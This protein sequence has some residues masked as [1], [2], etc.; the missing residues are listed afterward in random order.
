MKYKYIIQEHRADPVVVGA[1]AWNLWQIKDQV[2]VPEFVVVS[3]GAFQYFKEHGSIPE[4]L[5][6]EVVSVFNEIFSNK[7]IAV[8]SSGTAEDTKDRSYAGMYATTLNVSGV[9]ATIKAI[10]TVWESNDTRRVQSYR[11]AHKLVPG[12]MAVILQQQIDADVSGVMTTSGKQHGGEVIIECC[13]GLGDKLVSGQ[14]TP[15]RYLMKAKKILEHTGKDLLS[16]RQRFELYKTGQ[17]LQRVLGAP[18][19]IEW[20]YQ[21]NRLYILQAR[22]LTAAVQTTRK[23]VTVWCNANLRETIPDPIS[24]M[25]YSF[26]NEIWLPDIIINVFGFPLTRDQ[27]HEYPPVERVLGRMYWNLNNTAAYGRSIAPILNFMKGGAAVDPQFG[28]AMESIDI[29]YI[30]QLVPAFTMIRFTINAM[31]RMPFFLF[32]TYWRFRAAAQSIERAFL[33]VDQHAKRMAPAHDL[34]SGINNVREWVQAISDP[35][36]KRYFSGLLISV[37]YLALLIKLLGWR[38][39]KKGEAIARM[40]TYGLIDKTGEMVRA[41]QDLSSKAQQKLDSLSGKALAVLYEQDPAFHKQFDA[42]LDEFGHRGPAEFD[43]AS[44]NWR[45]DPGQ[46]L[47]IIKNMP[48][49][50]HT[51]SRESYIRRLLQNLPPCARF[52]VKGFLPRIEHLVPIRETGKHYLFKILGRV[53]EQLS[54]LDHD[55]RRRGWIKEKRD[56]YFLSLIDLKAIRDGNMSGDTV[57]RLIAQNK[58]E[59]DEYRN[60][61]APDIVYEDG[62]RTGMCALVKG[63]LSGTP[64]SFGRVQGRAR[65]IRSFKESQNLNQGEIM[66]THHTDPGWTPLFSIAGGVVIEVG[67]VICHAAMVARE[68]GLPAIVLPGATSSIPDG[69]QIELDADTGRVRIIEN[70]RASRGREKA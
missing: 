15:T 25:G 16:H 26:F 12:E 27:Y 21:D 47:R 8:R 33:K 45:E 42:F 39:G 1:K 9:E 38:M 10:K 36:G 46:V 40:T 69:A 56:I 2:R 43:A 4:G 48:S 59:W 51:E 7:P 28:A 17:L 18:Q 70:K 14:I 22:A 55:L 62:R 64:I 31:V 44:I 3:V 6:Q 61:A 20:A 34:Q 37:F 30:P 63:N 19:D 66:I 13:E 11:K 24:P 68:L 41:M 53:K 67:G 57:T 23:P 5:G 54:L 58:K 65:I 35:E 60:C 50:R 29:Q 32:K 49:T 52:I